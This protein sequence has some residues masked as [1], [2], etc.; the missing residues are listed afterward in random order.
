[1]RARVQ[2]I[3]DARDYIIAAVILII[4]A[5]LMVQRFQNGLNTLRSASVTVFSILEEPLSSVRVYRQALRTNT[6][7]QRQNIVLQDEL[8]KLR[9]LQQENRNLR[10]LLDLENYVDFDLL[11]VTIVGKELNGANNHFTIDAGSDKGVKNGMALITSEGLVGKVIKV[12][13]NYS[14]VMPYNN[15]LFRVSARV[16]DLRRAGI[17]SFSN[18]RT[19]ELEMEFIPQTI[20]VDSGMVIETSGYSNS[21]PVGIPIGYV[22]LTDPIEG[23]VYQRIFLKPFV[24]LTDVAEGFIVKYESIVEIDSL[25]TSETE[26][27]E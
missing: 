19:N 14:Q 25:I 16:Q 22:T 18:E 9:T 24:S 17:V 1:M 12:S 5:I 11:A 3:N 26:I 8:S 2:R 20:P 21:F 23:D 6:L 4:A 13:R 27:Q 15:A 10:S 7:L